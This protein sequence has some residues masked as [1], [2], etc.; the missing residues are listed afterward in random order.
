[1]K[2][3]QVADGSTKLR[4]Q[5]KR[6]RRAIEIAAA[7]IRYND[8]V[9]TVIGSDHGVFQ[10]LQTFDEH[11]TRPHV[12]NALDVRL[13]IRLEKARPARARIKFRAGAKQR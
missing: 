12:A 10:T 3:N 5:L 7:M 1:M 13:F 6:R 4:H 2:V 8:S 11:V 9:Q